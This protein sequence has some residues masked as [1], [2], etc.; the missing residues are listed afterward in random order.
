MTFSGNDLSAATISGAVTDPTGCQGAVNGALN[1]ITR[2]PATISGSYVASV[3]PYSGGSGTQKDLCVALLKNGG[4]ISRGDITEFW[5]ESADGAVR[6][7]YKT[8]AEVNGIFQDQSV[9][10]G[11]PGAGTVALSG[12]S[13]S[14]WAGL[15]TKYYSAL[16]AGDY[17]FYIKISDG[18]TVSDRVTIPAYEA[19]PVVNTGLSAQSDGNGGLVL[20]W[21]YPSE[22]FDELYVSIIVKDVVNNT[23]T[24]ILTIPVDPVT[25]IKNLLIP[26]NIMDS[27]YA[28]AQMGTNDVLMMELETRKYTSSGMLYAAGYSYAVI[29]IQ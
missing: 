22:T 2:R 19:A 21:E 11:D 27:V 12:S 6:D 17:I 1:L 25:Q 28:Q 8:E 20:A 5:M 14:T 23:K 3:V 15:L 18:Y 9:M 10:I 26:K 13:P 16:A 24:Y 29:K 7:A 4:N